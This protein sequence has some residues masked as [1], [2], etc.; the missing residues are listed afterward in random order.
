MRMLIT[1][2]IFFQLFKGRFF[3][4]ATQ[5]QMA[6]F[7]QCISYAGGQAGVFAHPNSKYRDPRIFEIPNN[8]LIQPEQPIKSKFAIWLLLTY[9]GFAQAIR[10]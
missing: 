10:A 9:I 6:K 7:E 5:S 2:L 8:L 1:N 4:F 3:A